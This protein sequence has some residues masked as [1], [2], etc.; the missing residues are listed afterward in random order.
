MPPSQALHT[1]TEY[2]NLATPVNFYETINED[3]TQFEV[4]YIGMDENEEKYKE[5]VRDM[6]W[7][8]YD[9][10]EPVKYQVYFEYKK[11][12]KGTSPRYARHPVSL[13]LESQQ[14][15]GH[16]EPGARICGEG[17]QGRLREVADS[18]E[19]QMILAIVI[20]LTYHISTQ[21]SKYSC[22]WSCE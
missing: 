7:L 12:V 4:I 1:H 10:R 18:D 3:I 8:F 19:L 2:E 15:A 20:T 17:G 9:F 14:R 21:Q 13:D 6:P 22:S 11:H 16:H 5:S